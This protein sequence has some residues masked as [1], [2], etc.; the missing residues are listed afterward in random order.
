MENKNKIGIIAVVILMFIIAISLISGCSTKSYDFSR[1]NKEYKSWC[2]SQ[3]GYYH[4]Y[5]TKTQV[6]TYQ[7]KDAE[8]IAVYDICEL[9]RDGKYCAEGYGCFSTMNLLKE[10]I[11]DK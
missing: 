10:E 6:K 2:S 5:H 9:P 7:G 4:E 11:S 3:G 1:E 8:M